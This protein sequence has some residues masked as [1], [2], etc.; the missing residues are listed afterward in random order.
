MSRQ[1]HIL[2]QNRR[3]SMVQFVAEDKMAYTR[4]SNGEPDA[5]HGFMRGRFKRPFLKS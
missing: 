3:E 2:R 4:S 1:R 5:M